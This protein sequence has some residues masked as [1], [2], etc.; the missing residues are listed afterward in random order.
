[1]RNFGGICLLLG[2]AGFLYFSSLQSALPD[3]PA[4]LSISQ[5]LEYPAG[6][7]EMGKYVAAIIGALGVLLALF[8]RGR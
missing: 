8:P 6:R 4:N 1:M 3:L 7:Y 5:T 2:I